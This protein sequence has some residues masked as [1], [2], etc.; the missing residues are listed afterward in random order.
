MCLLPW[1]LEGRRLA[2]R[3]GRPDGPLV[4]TE[5]PGRLLALKEQGGRTRV[6]PLPRHLHPKMEDGC[7]IEAEIPLEKGEAMLL[8]IKISPSWAEKE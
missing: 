7:Q 5:Q 4:V 2:R 6:H 1:R 3:G 8:E